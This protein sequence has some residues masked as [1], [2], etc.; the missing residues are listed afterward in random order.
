[1]INKLCTTQLCQPSKTKYMYI[2]KQDDA[3][4]KC[5]KQNKQDCTAK[6]NY[7][8]NC[9]ANN[10][11]SQKHS[12][13]H[14]QTYSFGLSSGIPVQ[15]QGKLSF[16][17]QGKNNE[18]KSL[19]SISTSYLGNVIRKLQSFSFSPQK[20]DFEACE[21]GDRLPLESRRPRA[22]EMNNGPLDR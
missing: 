18:T 1:M 13:I 12:Y 20:L 21:S 10:V 15:F 16:F 2:H 5:S 6:T 8:T 9:N 19:Q 22:K 4:R 7:Y 11:N 14:I 3:K 17:S